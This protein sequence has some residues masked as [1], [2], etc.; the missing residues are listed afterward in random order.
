MKWVH[1]G[2]VPGRNLLKS[3]SVS[4]EVVVTDMFKDCKAQLSELR[5]SVDCT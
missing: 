3:T 4:D 2:R 5:T 1:A